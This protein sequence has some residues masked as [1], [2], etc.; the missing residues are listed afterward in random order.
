[1]KS[2]AASAE[3]LTHTAPPRPV[4]K[5]PPARLGARGHALATTQTVAVSTRPPVFYAVKSLAPLIV[6]AVIM[7]ATRQHPADLGET[8]QAVWKVPRR[9][10]VVSR[11]WHGPGLDVRGQGKT[12]AA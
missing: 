7:A 11:L 5:V 2:L 6:L 4:T 3:T 9:A 12:G 8:T 1:M 10:A